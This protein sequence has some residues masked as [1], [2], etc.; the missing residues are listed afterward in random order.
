[1]G[2]TPHT[3]TEQKLPSDFIL[4]VNDRLARIETRVEI[5]RTLLIAIFLGVVSQGGL[6]V[7]QT[8]ASG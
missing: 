2:H 6:I 3:N 5:H 4:E 7:W 1:M 8:A